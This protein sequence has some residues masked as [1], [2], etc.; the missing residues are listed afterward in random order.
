MQAL[1]LQSWN[2]VRD[3]APYYN[4]ASASVGYFGN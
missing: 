1:D 4:T 3:L 2:Y